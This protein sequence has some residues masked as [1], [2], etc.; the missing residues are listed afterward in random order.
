ME[1][2]YESSASDADSACRVAHAA[3]ELMNF[4]NGRRPAHRLW[5]TG[6]PLA[7][8]SHSE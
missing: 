5:P 2:N 8:R 6:S 1:W 7:C 4:E 3:V